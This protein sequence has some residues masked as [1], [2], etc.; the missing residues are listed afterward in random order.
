MA[1]LALFPVILTCLLGFALFHMKNNVQGLEEE[2][3]SL[4]EKILTEKEAIH[5]LKAEWS[6]LNN[7]ERLALLNEKYLQYD[8]LEVKAIVELATLPE[9]ACP[10][11]KP[12]AIALPEEQVMLINHVKPSE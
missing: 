10:A 4:Q 8:P 7:P 6:Y 11:P 3:A 9:K 12:E 1:K 2:L 5:V